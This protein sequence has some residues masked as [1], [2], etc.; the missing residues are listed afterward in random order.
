MRNYVNTM[1]TYGS[2]GNTAARILDRGL[3]GDKWQLHGLDAL[4]LEEAPPGV[5]F[6]GGWVYPGTDLVLVNEENISHPCRKS[7]SDSLVG[8]PV[9]W[10]P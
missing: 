4:P 10:S 8:Q 2:W 9:G 6:I 7:S 1:N 5:R 3:D